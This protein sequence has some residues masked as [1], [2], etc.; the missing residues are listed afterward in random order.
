MNDRSSSLDITTD[1]VALTTNEDGTRM[2]INGNESGIYNTNQGRRRSNAELLGFLEFD[3]LHS[4]PLPQQHSR[5]SS[6]APAQHRTTREY[7][8]NQQHFSQ[9]HNQQHQ[10][11]NGCDEIMFEA[12][13][14][15]DSEDYCVGGYHNVKIGETF[16]RGRYRALKKLGWGHFSTVWLAY[17]GIS[18][19]HV[20]IKFQKSAPHYAEAARDEIRILN[21][22]KVRDPHRTAPVVHLLDNFVHRGSN[23]THV[24][25]VFEVLGKS[26]LSLVK[27]CNFRGA[28]LPL[29]KLIAYQV[30][31]GLEF[32]STECGIIHTDVKP[33]NILFVPPRMEYERLRYTARRAVELMTQQ[34]AQVDPVRAEQLGL[35]VE[36]EER[37]ARGGGRNELVSLSSSRSS[38]C[39]S[40]SSGDIDADIR[41]DEF[42]E[43]ELEVKE[44]SNENRVDQETLRARRRI[45]ARMVS[46]RNRRQHGG[47]LENIDGALNPIE[48]PSFLFDSY[49]SNPELEFSSGFVKMVD[50][51]NAC[52]KDQHFTEDIQ[53]RQYR[54]PEVI[55]GVEYDCSTD[56]WSLA[57]V[58]FEIATGDFLF[59]PHSGRDF[60]R[61]EDHLALMMELLGPIPRSFLLRGIYSRDFF[62]SNGDLRHIHTM[63]YWSL[64]DVLVEKYRFQ[65]DDA[66]SFCSFLLSMLRFDPAQRSTVEECLRHSWLSNVP[67]LLEEMKRLDELNAAEYRETL[68][69][70]TSNASTQSNPTR[71]AVTTTPRSTAQQL[72]QSNVVE[73]N[74]NVQSTEM[75]TDEI[76]TRMEQIEIESNV[77]HVQEVSNLNRNPSIG[78]ESA[79]NTSHSRSRTTES[80]ASQPINPDFDP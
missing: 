80:V 4:T 35:G 77:Q 39:S 75:N 34:Q 6:N 27:R 36:R 7:S 46:R 11:L 23:G 69:G 66:T 56:I 42:T 10:Q 21:E 68:Y 54:S 24:C 18:K 58:L 12:S 60:D 65:R 49:E 50:F 30:L 1:G 43:D 29:V 44:E 13:E 76:S 52:W 31:K 45:S 57:C 59:D 55:L 53:T 2:Q 61:D 70:T 17:D 16:K 41:E 71:N 20:A 15:E 37:E 67:E 47:I 3:R 73:N 14:S 40:G 5:S 19:S 32:I 8:Q 79:V 62:A 78:T 22:L 26:L 9:Q 74:A 25:L 72:Q 48:I 51:G 28:P 33:E 63:N 38:C 64:A